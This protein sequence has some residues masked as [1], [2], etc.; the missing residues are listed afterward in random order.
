[1]ATDAPDRTAETELAEPGTV[2]RGISWKTYC[3]LRDNEHNYHVRMTYLDGTLI[4]M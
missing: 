4:L 1:M 2:L 3:R